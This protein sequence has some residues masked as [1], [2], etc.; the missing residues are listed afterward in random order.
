MTSGRSY[1][2]RWIF[3]LDLCGGLL[4]GSAL[5][6]DVEVV[7]KKTVV[8]NG[9][10]QQA[11]HPMQTGPAV[12]DHKNYISYMD[13][14]GS[15]VC[16]TSGDAGAHNIFV[17][18]LDLATNKW[19]PS[20]SV[21]VI[22]PKGWDGH[23]T[24]TVFRGP[25]GRLDVFYG[26]ISS[27]QN[28]SAG[29][30]ADTQGP[31]YRRSANPDNIASWGPVQRVPVCGAFSEH[32][33]GY[34]AN[35]SLHLF[36]QKQWS[37]PGLPSYDLIYIRRSEDLSWSSGVALI[38]DDGKDSSKGQNGPGCMHN[39]QI[40]G[41][42][43][44]LVWSSTTNSC[45]GN[46]Q[47]LYYAWS[48]DN[49]E[50]WYNADKTASFKREKGLGAVSA[51][52]YPSS[53]LVKSGDTTADMKV[54]A[55]S[56]G[57]VIIAHRANG[58]LELHRRSKGNWQRSVIESSGMNSVVGLTIG[59]TATDVIAVVS[60]NGSDVFLYTSSDKGETWAKQVLHKRGSEAN[61]RNFLSTMVT[62]SGLDNR[63][64]V[65]WVETFY[66]G[67]PRPQFHTEVIVSE[68]R[69]PAPA[70]PP[71][72]APAPSTPAPTA[73]IISPKAF[74]VVRVWF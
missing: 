53:Y 63:M 14:S 72:T 8:T 37:S 11:T 58:L 3:C 67:E 10:C 56:D 45:S 41:N 50:T 52:T 62:S 65:E 6:V 2:L 60:G 48:T 25:D 38:H 20:P 74:R 39:E 59:I 40:I 73:R 27:G 12:G 19:S 5:A 16:H 69:F 68:I 17:S 28:A 36:G 4:L 49:G 30:S 71:P 31:F 26:A 34:T 54:N 42:T 15:S 46:G 57:S 33:G 9:Y 21:G 70:L 55:L 44:H 32:S 61:N 13:N 18:Q 7:S 47:N 29:C 1:I 51:L 64:F 24:P 22:D 23:E 35:G 43:I 66:P